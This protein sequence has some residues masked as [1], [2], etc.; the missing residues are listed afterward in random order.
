MTAWTRDEALTFAHHVIA[1]SDPH[2]SGT[3]R[4]A[5]ALIDAHEET[6]RLRISEDDRRVL[7]TFAA[8]RSSVVY[9]PETVLAIERVLA[10]YEAP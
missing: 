3:I 9:Y 8:D 6:V 1:E 7:F 5:R 10:K 2:K 4:L